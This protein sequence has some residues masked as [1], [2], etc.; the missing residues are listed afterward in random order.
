[1]GKMSGGKH[2]QQSMCK[3]ARH[4]AA[5]NQFEKIATK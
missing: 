5:E 2:L 3:R 4:T 1:M